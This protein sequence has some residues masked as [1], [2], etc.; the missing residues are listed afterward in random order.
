MLLRKYE[1]TDAIKILSWIDSE[2]AFRLWSAD[3]YGDYPITEDDVNDNY[4]QCAQNGD[5]YPMT[6]IDDNENIVG[7]LILR[8]SDKYSNVIRLGFI[9]V[10]NKIRGRGYGKLMIKC[11]IDYAKNKLNAKEISLGVFKNNESAYKCYCSVGFK[12]V[13]I[14]KSA[15]IF[16]EESWDCIEMILKE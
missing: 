7:H 14:E 10:D 9:I 12:E 3:R 4:R 13:E 15:Y 6:L 11:A 8:K 1:E 16:Y 5:F 2:R